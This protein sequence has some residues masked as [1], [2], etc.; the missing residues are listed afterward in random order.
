M[1][2]LHRKQF[3]LAVIFTG[4]VVLLSSAVVRGDI[5]GDIA[6]TVEPVERFE[7]TSHG[8]VEYRFVVENLSSQFSREVTLSL[9]NESYG[10]GERIKQ[11][12]RTVVV[13]PKSTALVSLWQPPIAIRGS[14]MTVNIDGQRYKMS[15]TTVN[16]L[17]EFTSYGPYIS[18][19]YGSGRSRASI[20]QSRG[21]KSDCQTLADK[22]IP[23][24]K[25][26]SSSRRSTSGRQQD[27]EIRRSESEVNRWSSNWLGYPRYDGVMVSADEMR[28]MPA[29]VRSRSF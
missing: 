11:I 14:D 4:L 22:A 24:K 19:V 25:S 5:F 9:P 1:K 3:F 27:Y 13:G 16:H 7:K 28:L 12:K 26:S 18:I 2:V 29:P 21:I 10:T 15:M 17:S 23:V 8:Y 20:L 6:V